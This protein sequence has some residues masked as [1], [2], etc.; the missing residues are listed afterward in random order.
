MIDF[1]THIMPEI[2][3]GSS[4]EYE[5]IQ[6]L[7]MLKEQG[8][9]KVLLTPHFY[10]YSSSAETFD[11]LRESSLKALLEALSDSPLDVQ[12]YLGCEVYY[13]EE[14][15]R[16]EK[17]RDFCIKGTDYILIEMP[18]SAWTDNMVRGIEKIIGKGITPIIAHFE[19]Y[20]SYGN[21]PKIYELIEMGALLQ[22]NC[23]YINR[24]TTRRKA[25]KLIKKDIVAVLGS[26][27]HN[28]YKRRPEYLSAVKY[29]RKK[30][31]EERFNRFFSFQK[32]ILSKAE[33]VYSQEQNKIQ[34]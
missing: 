13:F 9:D 30:L 25:I 31:S 7:K 2:D 18:F 4:S 16:V 5:S 6:L 27:C 28:V 3:D 14:L 17:L 29:L 15:W 12:L 34:K 24:F 32:R 33:P 19:R 22:M 8:V 11:E 10:A 1:H 20:I 21:M 23:D 26:D